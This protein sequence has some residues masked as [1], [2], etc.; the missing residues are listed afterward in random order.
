MEACRAL[1]ARAA[2][3]PRLDDALRA[4]RDFVMREDLLN[5]VE[6]HVRLAAAENRLDDAV[7][8][9]SAV[10]QARQRLALV[11]RQHSQAQWEALVNLLR[12]RAGAESFD[13]AWALGSQWEIDEMTQRALARLENS[14]AA[15]R[16]GAAVAA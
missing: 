13:V 10:E 7:G 3:G 15:Q 9:A 12:Q 6:D 11:R 1:G 5:C 16:E 14:R 2:A 4:L 8:L